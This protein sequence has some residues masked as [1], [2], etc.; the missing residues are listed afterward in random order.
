MTER[1]KS[2]SLGMVLKDSEGKIKSSRL[3]FRDPKKGKIEEKDKSIDVKY[4]GR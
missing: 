2:G 4:K 1:K 3:I